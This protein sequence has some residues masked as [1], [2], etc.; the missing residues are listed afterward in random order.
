MSTTNMLRALTDNIVVDKERCV[1]CGICVERCPMDNLRLNLSPCR[2]GCPLGVNAQGYVQLVARGEEEK[3]LALVREELP[4]PGILGRICSQPCESKC[5][6]NQVKSSPISIRAIKRYLADRY[7]HLK[8]APPEC[9]NDTGKK[10]AVIG[11]G[12]AGLMAAY[13][14]RLRG[15]GAVVFDANKSPGG[16]LRTAIPEFRL[17][18]EV[19]EREL[20]LLSDMGVRFLLDHA[21]GRD[22][23][24]DEIIHEYDAVLLATGCPRPKYLGIEGE[25]LVGVRHALDFLREIRAGKASEPGARVAVI[26]GGNAAVD[27]AQSA[28]RLGA[29]EVKM[30]CLEGEEGMP[31]FPRALEEARE[32]CVGILNSWGPVRF[33]GE[34]GRIKGIEFH[35]CRQLYDEQGRFR[36]L[37][38]SCEAMTLDVDCAIIAAGQERD[39]SLLKGFGISG[40]TGSFDPLTMETSRKNIFLAGD[41]AGGPSTVVDAMASGRRAAESI[42]RFVCGEDMRYGRAYRGPVETEFEIDT[43]GFIDTTRADVPRRS[44]TDAPDFG[45]IE[46]ALSTEAARREAAR[47]FSCGRPFGKYRNCWFCLPCEIECPH[48]ALHVEIPYLLR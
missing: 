41:C 3:A 26:G 39:D 15:H 45:E 6:H 7:A 20:S 1:A 27:A 22:V 10:I 48:E 12:P 37:L 44:C 33:L 5:H 19:L 35:R 36:P 40:A 34:G 23:L 31:A 38:D 18:V 4:F 2:Q 32:E 42:H 14:L 21:V 24:C 25:D 16:M 11:A 29:R 9:V 30:I 47:C 43:G 13:E 46:G 28:L 8:P 17:P